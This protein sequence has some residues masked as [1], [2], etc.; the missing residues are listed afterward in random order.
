[1]RSDGHKTSDFVITTVHERMRV[2]SV[3]T[4]SQVL[5]SRT[6]RVITRSRTEH[7]RYLVCVAHWGLVAK[8]TVTGRKSL[9]DRYVTVV[10]F[11]SATVADLCPPRLCPREVLIHISGF[12]SGHSVL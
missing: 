6:S 12:V 9:C 2:D 1:M 5:F 8:S 10:T 7:E 4:K 11:V 3:I